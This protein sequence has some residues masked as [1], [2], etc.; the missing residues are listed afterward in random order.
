MKRK[1][2]KDNIRIITF[3]AYD[4]SGASDV[5]TDI[6]WTINIKLGK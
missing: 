4:H 6:V 5:D 2:K 3:L 1:T